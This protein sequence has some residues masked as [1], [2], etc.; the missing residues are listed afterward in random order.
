MTTEEPKPEPKPKPR[1]RRESRGGL[2]ALSIII[3]VLALV[4]LCSSAAIAIVVMMLHESDGHQAKSDDANLVE[5]YSQLDEV[6]SPRRVGKMIVE[7]SLKRI[8]FR[9]FLN[10]QPMSTLFFTSLVRFFLC[11]LIVLGA[12]FTLVSNAIGPR[13]IL[14]SCLC[15]VVVGLIEALSLLHSGYAIATE[16]Y[17]DFECSYR[18]VIDLANIEGEYRNPFGGVKTLE[19]ET[20]KLIGLVYFGGATMLWQIAALSVAFCKPLLPRESKLN[21]SEGDA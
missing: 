19:L 15:L 17:R 9:P 13:F 18:H 3:A 21:S 10:R 12:I 1:P 16:F 4:G 11:G 5:R 8:D 6:D 7:D 20:V 14:G 2:K